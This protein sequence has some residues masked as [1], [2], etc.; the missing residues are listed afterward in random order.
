VVT[1]S[2][3]VPSYA[4]KYTSV[5]AAERVL[6]VKAVA[7]DIE[8]RLAKDLKRTDS[9]IAHAAVNAL[10]WNVEIPE[11]K[12][13]VRVDEGWITLDGELEWQ[14][15]RNAVERAVRTLS[16][17]KGVT[18]LILVKPSAPSPSEVGKNIR[19]ALRRSAEQD[20]D[21]ITVDASNGRITLHGKV[22]TWVERQDA[23]RAAWSAPGVREV[24]DQITVGV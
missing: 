3:Q 21:K 14:Y 7:N 5:K 9:D 10:A 12:V 4:M 22:R 8:V 16:G 17:V 18:N 23:E 11:N 24:V 15:Q 19:D 1:L 6:G 20:A 13:K 2:G